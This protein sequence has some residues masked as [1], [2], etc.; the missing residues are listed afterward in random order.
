MRSKQCSWSK[1]LAVQP[2]EHPA[3]ALGFAELMVGRCRAGPGPHL[4]LDLSWCPPSLLCQ[5]S[6]AVCIAQGRKCNTHV[7]VHTE[8]RTHKNRPPHA[9]VDAHLYTDVS[10]QTCPCSPTQAHAYRQACT[11]RPVHPDAHTYMHERVLMFAHRCA[12][13]RVFMYIL[14]WH[15]KVH[16]YTCT[17]TQT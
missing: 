1:V 15:A 8:T 12:H 3:H 6:T 16:S 4:P 9:E 17:H 13:T 5:I 2:W 7:C 14:R 11:Q 10:T